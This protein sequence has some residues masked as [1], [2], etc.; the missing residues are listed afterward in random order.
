MSSTNKGTK[1]ATHQDDIKI[2]VNQTPIAGITLMKQYDGSDEDYEILGD[3]VQKRNIKPG[4]VAS[5]VAVV[6]NKSDKDADVAVYNLV[7]GA[8]N[9]VKSFELGD[10]V[11]IP[12]GS[13]GEISAPERALLNGETQKLF[14][15]N[16]NLMPLSQ[17]SDPLGLVAAQVP[18]SV[19]L[20]WNNQNYPGYFI[21][22][23]R[24]DQIVGRTN[25]DYCILDNL[26]KGTNTIYVDLADSYGRVLLRSKPIDVIVK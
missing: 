1:L 22:I 17:T 23:Y 2:T 14:V 18:G 4:D 11:T 20:W 13:T 16:S 3:G 15:W 9:N 8:D 6:T 12:A 21:N 7:Y 26:K 5:P 19:K 10:V 24:G 25:G